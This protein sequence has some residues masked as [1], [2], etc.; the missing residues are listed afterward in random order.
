MPI[1]YGTAL[2]L[3]QAP[4]A[5]P[6]EVVWAQDYLRVRPQQSLD[7]LRFSTRVRVRRAGVPIYRSPA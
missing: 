1:V 4:I 6:Y 7:R 5:R 2:L 3:A